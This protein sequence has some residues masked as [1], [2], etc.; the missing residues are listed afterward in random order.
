VSEPTQ[1]MPPSEPHGLGASL[2]GSAP[3]P[4]AGDS[5]PGEPSAPHGGAQLAGDPRPKRPWHPRQIV[6]ALW[7]EVRFYASEPP[8]FWTVL[9]PFTLLAILLFARHP[10][11]NFIFD[12]QEALLANPYVNGKQ[13]LTFLDAVHRDFWGLP[14]NASVGSYR[15]LPNFFW[16]ALWQV[17]Q[18]PFFHHAYNVL[19]HAA[20]AAMLSSLALRLTSRRDL[21]WLAGLVFLCSA[22]LTEA[23]TGIVGIAD[24]WGG[25]G[26]LLA[27]L[28]LGLR[29]P[30]MPVAVF[31]ATLFSLFS[32]ESGI[33]LVPLVPFAALL[34]APLFHPERPARFHRA[35]VSFVSTFAAFVLY[36]ELRKRWFDSP[37][38]DEVQRITPR[39]VTTALLDPAQP[40]LGVR[41]DIVVTSGQSWFRDF[42]VWFHQAGLPRDPLNNPLIQADTPHRIAGALRVYA[43]G[44]GQL[45]LP[46]SLSPD[47]SFPQEPIPAKLVFPESVMGGA[48]L[49]LPPLGALGLWLTSLWRERTLGRPRSDKGGRFRLAGRLV[50]Y[51]V[52]VAS[53]GAMLLAP[54]VLVPALAWPYWPITISGWVLVLLAAMMLSLDA[55][56]VPD[57]SAPPPPPALASPLLVAVGLVW[58]VVSYFPHSNIPVLLPTVRAE[59]F[60]YFPALGT[61]LVFALA[62]AWLLA[63][64]RVA[65]AGVTEWTWQARARVLVPGGLAVAFVLVQCVQAYRHTRNYREDI[66]LWEA[67]VRAVPNSAKA[68]LNYSVMKGARGDYDTRLFHSQE[69]MRLAPKWA[70]AHVYTGDV[71]CRMNR[72]EEAWPHFYDGFRIGPNEQSLIALALQCMWDNKVV[73]VREDDLRTLARD[74]PGSWIAYLGV[75]ILDNG[76]THNG[77]DPK[78]RPRGYNE[79]AKD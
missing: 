26:A 22:V 50:V 75:D 55:G 31:G 58:C 2:T 51:G 30:A 79:G 33:V 68:H 3:Q 11:T 15:P 12:E 67:A 16:R 63:R 69:A 52:L 21:G 4:S 24:V 8:T 60:W 25:L 71:L 78:Y 17:S 45:V 20:N 43:R 49:A 54:P 46:T 7:D 23:V 56:H 14:A 35:L 40:E 65:F 27:L 59:R 39:L 66:A 64:S 34:W 41:A 42:L 28:A 47:Y 19:F 1:P 5:F 62:L 72:H 9:G 61:S 76:E 57:A 74:F 32:K 38:P 10:A 37:L 53:L 73:K 6:Q 18:K 70:M 36:V 77:V 29:G 44:L 13:G 48:L